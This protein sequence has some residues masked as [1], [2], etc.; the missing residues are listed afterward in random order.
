MT[1]P[2]FPQPILQQ[3][4]GTR[5]YLEVSNAGVLSARAITVDA[6]WGQPRLTLVS[7]DRTKAYRLGLSAGA[8]PTVTTTEVPAS[9]GGFAELFVFS[10]NGREWAVTVDAAGSLTVTGIGSDWP[11]IT[12][13]VL[14]DSSNIPWHLRVTDGGVLSV[15]S[16]NAPQALQSL[17][18]RSQDGTAA[19]RVSISTDGILSVDTAALSD[20]I[21]YDAEVVSSAGTR[22]SIQ[23]DANGILSMNSIFEDLESERDQWPLVLAKDGTLYCADTRFRAPVSAR[24]KR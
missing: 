7:T 24:R 15:E 16:S 22:W 21:Y 19:Y 10:P 1:Y 11:R 18:L 8:S 9:F 2:L 12:S 20:A 13:P 17:I 5:W 3:A 4:S 6:A 23:V 14:K